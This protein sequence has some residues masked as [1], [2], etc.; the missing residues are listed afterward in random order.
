[1]SSITRTEK[2]YNSIASGEKTGITPITREEQYLSYIAGEST[3]LPSEP[4]TRKEMYL[5]KIADNGVSGGVTPSGT[6]NITENGTHDVTQYASAEVNVP[7]PDGYIQP[8]GA[9]NVTEN[10]TIDVKYYETANVNVPIPSDYIKPS[11]SLEITANGTVD[12]KYYETANVNVPVTALIKVGEMTVTYTKNEIDCTSYANYDKW[13]T[14]DFYIVPKAFTVFSTTTGVTTGSI[15]LGTYSFSQSYSNGKFSAQRA[16]VNGQV[17][18]SFPCDVYV[19]DKTGANIPIPDG[20]IKPSGS[21]E[22]T[23]NG[24]Y[25]VTDKAEVVV[26]VA[27]GGDTLKT[28]LDATKS[29]KSLF[30]GYEGTS[31]DGLIPYSA[32]ENVTNMQYMFHQC[33]NLTTVPLFDTSKVTNTY[34]MF[35]QCS[36]LTTVPLFDTSKVTNTTNMFYD[37][38]SLTTVPLFDTSKVTSTNS[39]FQGCTNL[40]TVPSLNFSSAVTTT[41]MFYN[42]TSLTTVPSLNFSSATELGS[43][44]KGCTKLTTV[45]ELNVSNVTKVPYMFMN[46]TS[47]KKVKLKNV[48]EKI[49]YT[50]DWFRKCT[51]LE[52]IDFRGAI[53]V[54]TLSYTGDFTNVPSTCKVVI[55]DSLYDTWVNATNWSA[56]NVTWVKE[57]EYVE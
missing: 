23:E 53:S 54:P 32:T 22:Y 42:C 51:S 17:G 26:N 6:I 29:S 34:G 30:S 55:P 57:S 37:C 16:S 45:S 3:T 36:N 38:T 5:Q 56:I 10:G 7:I 48:S 15:T 25:D 1:M 43:L 24:T 40:T 39:M 52:V 12:V 50:S 28:L 31:V 4:I 18:L 11:G 20:Y 35:Y 9:I 33:S 19:Y 13:T 21:V 41:N 27:S 49:T 47:L 8:S 46:C 2:L 14:N 44:F